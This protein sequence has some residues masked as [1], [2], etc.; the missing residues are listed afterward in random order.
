VDDLVARLLAA[1]EDS[2]AGTSYTAA[3]RRILRQLELRGPSTLA[4]LG[5]G[6]PV[7][8]KHLAHLVHELEQ[9]GLVEPDGRT[10]GQP[11]VRLT[12]DGRTALA[13]TRTLQLDLITKLLDATARED[14]TLANAMWRRLRAA[15]DS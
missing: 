2:V 12:A 10:D 1:A 15:L 9:D 14:S 6:W 3:R 5:H 13:A 11:H 8:P 4:G 7:T